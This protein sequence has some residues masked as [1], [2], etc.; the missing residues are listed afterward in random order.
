MQRFFFP[1]TLPWL[2]HEHLKEIVHY[3]DEEH[4]EVIFYDDELLDDIFWSEV[5]APKTLRCFMNDPLGGYSFLTSCLALSERGTGQ[6]FSEEIASLISILESSRRMSISL[7]KH[8]AEHISLGGDPIRVTPITPFVDYVRQFVLEK[9]DPKNPVEIERFCKNPTNPGEFL[10]AY[11]NY[12]TTYEH[13]HFDVLYCLVS[14]MN[15]P[16]F[17]HYTTAIF[18][19]N[20]GLKVL[21]R[22]IQFSF[23]KMLTRYRLVNVDLDMIDEEIIPF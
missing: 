21:P 9:H 16:T 2:V 11:V 7:I 17:A 6:R 20:K 8:Y 14:L 4:E 1:Y 19:L 10:R 3:V 22:D 5:N 13:D 23:S 15:A 18:G 12:A